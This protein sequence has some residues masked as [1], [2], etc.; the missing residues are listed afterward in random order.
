[1]AGTRKKAT[2]SLKLN[3]K[4]ILAQWMLSQFGAESLEDLAKDLTEEGLDESNTHHSRGAK[5]W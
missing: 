3:R 5:A 1:M 4:L 2:A